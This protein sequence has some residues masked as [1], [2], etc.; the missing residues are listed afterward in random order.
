M[1]F[2]YRQTALAATSHCLNVH[3]S[4]MRQ[5]GPLSAGTRVFH[6][7]EMV[8]GQILSLPL[9]PAYVDPRPDPLWLGMRVVPPAIDDDKRMPM[10]EWMAGLGATLGRQVG[11][12]ADALGRAVMLSIRRRVG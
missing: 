2:K 6:P 1:T 7:V 3:M 9:M 8:V 12:A 5:L 4:P 11:D 10:R